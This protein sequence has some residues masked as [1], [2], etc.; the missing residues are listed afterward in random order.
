MN[1][2]IFTF[3]IACM[4]TLYCASYA[5]TDYN[6]FVAGVR[7]TSN[8]AANITGEGISGSVSY[9]EQTKTL[10]LNNASINSPNH[11]GINNAEIDGLN[12]ELIG[13]NTINSPAYACIALEANSVI[14]GTGYINLT[15]SN[16]MGIL[17]K[18]VTLTIS[19]CSVEASGKW[20]I[21]G[22]NGTSGETLIVNNA[23]VKATGERFGSIISLATLTLDNCAIVEPANAIF[24]S[25]KHAV[26]ESGQTVK[27][28]VVI[29]PGITTIVYGLKI[30]EVQVTSTNASNI[31]GEGIS[32]AL[33]YNHDT[34]TLTL[35]NA[36]IEATVTRGVFNENIDG[37]TINLVGNNIISAISE[38]ASGISVYKNTTITGKGNLVVTSNDHAGI[39]INDNATLRIG[40]EECIVESKGKWGISGYDGSKNESLTIEKATV[41]SLGTKGSVCDLSS[42]M[43]IGSVVRQPQGAIFN[44]STKC[45]EL[46]GEKITTEVLITPIGTDITPTVADKGLIMWSENSILYIKNTKYDNRIKVT[47]YTADG[48]LI[49]DIVVSNKEMTVNLTKGI[50]VIKAGNTV[51]KIIVK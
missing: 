2:K 39:Y 21:T 47:I 45:L 24:D 38:N 27:S 11:Y 29:A 18:K 33:S 26:V 16:D 41:K 49:K 15:S 46:N 28:Q 19:E 22:W 5:Q 43:L 13:N 35:D 12:I 23:S 30:A 32:G 37:L 25:S 7:V 42:F 1:R 50:Y 6:L 10:T 51:E 14:R 36:T 34:K 9:N 44:N 4:A 48:R 8:N 3:F 20:G 17:I 31:K 40:G